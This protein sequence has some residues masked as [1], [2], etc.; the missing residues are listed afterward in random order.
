MLRHLERQYI[1]GS[2]GM[3]HAKEYATGEG[4][5]CVRK[6]DGPSIVTATFLTRPFQDWHDAE[7]PVEHFPTKPRHPECHQFGKGSSRWYHHHYHYHCHDH[8]HDDWTEM[9]RKYSLT[10][11]LSC[12]PGMSQNPKL[13]H[14][15]FFLSTP[16]RF[17]IQCV[18]TSRVRSML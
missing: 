11:R 10:E 18:H 13:T 6:P 4:G 14:R 17:R 15:V 12:K 8:D 9:N 7:Q 5:P 1:S 3:R 16:M 2:K